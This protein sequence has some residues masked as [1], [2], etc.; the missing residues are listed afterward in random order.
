ML[1]AR[2]SEKN[3]NTIPVLQG[4]VLQLIRGIRGQIIGASIPKTA[5]G[6]GLPEKQGTE[7]G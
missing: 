2:E 5:A 1:G 3:G 6:D 7:G 4:S